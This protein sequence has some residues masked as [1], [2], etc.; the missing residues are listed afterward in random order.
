M[1][2]NSGQQAPCLDRIPE[3]HESQGMQSKPWH[4]F[5]LSVGADDVGDNLRHIGL[6]TFEVSDYIAAAQNHDPS[7][8][9]EDVV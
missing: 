7:T 6:V 5:F 3:R 1:F 9:F 2:E 4:I 8:G